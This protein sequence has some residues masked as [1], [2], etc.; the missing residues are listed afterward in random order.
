MT[1]QYCLDEASSRS[2]NSSAAP[3]KTPMAIRPLYESLLSG[4]LFVCS[5]AVKNI[6]DGYDSCHS[7]RSEASDPRSSTT[8]TSLEHITLHFC[9]PIP[10]LPSSTRPRRSNVCPWLQAAP[11]RSCYFALSNSPPPLILHGHYDRDGW[12]H[13][14]QSLL[15]RSP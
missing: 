7:L 4:D 14:V 3:T 15:Q 10:S 1:A 11:A 9:T 5:A 13:T 8:T 6:S 2:E 12:Q